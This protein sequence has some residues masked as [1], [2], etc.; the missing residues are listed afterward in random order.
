MPHMKSLDEHG[1]KGS[2]WIHTHS[3]RDVT[4]ALTLENS[5]SVLRGPLSKC[6]GV[7]LIAGVCYVSTL[8]HK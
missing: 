5:Q 8:M 2:L 4:C 3:T 1:S 6:V 7:S